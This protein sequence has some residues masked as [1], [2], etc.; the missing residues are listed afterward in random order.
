MSAIG[1]GYVKNFDGGVAYTLTRD[2][3]G[4]VVGYVITSNHMTFTVQDH[5]GRKMHE[6]PR[7]HGFVS[8]VLKFHQWELSH[9]ITR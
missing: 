8:A 6:G 9:G 3:D 5:N 2:S 4:A 1:V 7:S